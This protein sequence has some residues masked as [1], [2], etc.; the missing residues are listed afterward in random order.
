MPRPKIKVA[1][2]SYYSG[3][4]S[5]GVETFV[6]ELSSRARP[7]FKVVV[8]HE[9]PDQIIMP[10]KFLNPLAIAFF[11]LKTLFSLASDP[12][13]ILMP[14]NNNW[15]SLFS[16][17]FCFFFKTKLILAGFAGIGR[18]DKLNLWLNPDRFICCTQAQSDWAKT[19]NPKAKLSVIP[20][21]VN[22]DRFKPEG[23]KFSLN[24]KPPVILCVAGPE[25]YKR[26]DLAIRAVK[27][28]SASLLVVG[29]QSESTNQLGKKLLGLRYQNLQIDYQNLDS[30][31]RSADLF[32]LPSESTEAYGITI[33]EAMASGLPVVVNNDPIRKE[34]TGEAGILINPA[35][36]NNYQQAL[37][38]AL[39]IKNRSYLRL[40]ALKFSWDSIIDQYQKLWQS[41]AC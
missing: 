31:Y 9:K 29:H 23:K 33:L 35:D 41:L 37:Q 27:Q 24:L 18:I 2:I 12:P 6:A 8:Y 5:R 22:T 34:L 7:G 40:Q 3:Y 11:T 17:F 14:L 36:L 26:I 1:I 39:K 4:V 38:K 19:I 32:T 16:K 15:M 10:G 13:D 20:I 21:G 30:V 25:K 28:T